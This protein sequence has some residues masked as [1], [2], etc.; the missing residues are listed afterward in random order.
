MDNNLKFR[1]YDRILSQLTVVR[2][3]KL[4]GAK[5][6]LVLTKNKGAMKEYTRRFSEVDLLQYTTLKDI[7][8]TELFDGDVVEFP[9]NYIYKNNKHFYAVVERLNGNVYVHDRLLC[10]VSD[11]VYKIGNIYADNARV[12]SK[13]PRI[14]QKKW[15]M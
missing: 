14:E 4:V 10:D 1:A 15:R 12:I 6:F 5:K 11:I 13:L 2:G 9:I 8:N 7:K 3:M